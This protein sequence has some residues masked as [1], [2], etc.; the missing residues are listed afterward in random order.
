[1]TATAD[2]QTSV[3]AWKSPVTSY[4]LLLTATSILVLMGL[5][6]VLSS[7]SISSIAS[8][9]GS[10]YSGF[11]TQAIALVVGATAL[12]VGSRLSPA[13]WKI[14][15]PIVLY[16]SMALLVAVP[17]IGT[18]VGGNKAWIRLGSFSFQPSE[19]AKVGLALYLGVV[20]ARFRHGLTTIKA[21][22]VPGGLMA[23]AV[24]ALVLWG[25]DMG[26]ALVLMALILVAF[27]VAGV[28]KRFFGMAGVA[29]VIGL[30]A[31]VNV[32][33]TRLARIEQWFTG[34]C[35][36]DSC[37]QQQHGTWA[38]ASGG[39]GGLGPGMSR[40][41][42]GY[43]PASDNDFIFAIIGEE[44]GLIG[45][46]LVLIAFAL[47]VLAVNRIIQR[48]DDRFVQIAAAGIGAAVCIQACI[49][50]AV[51]LE[52]LPV[53]GV[54]L[55]LVSAGGSSL[56]VSLLAMGVLM[57]FAR[58]EPGAQ[59]VL[60]ARPSLVRRSLSVLSKGRRRG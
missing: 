30:V 33:E 56:I 22:L 11:V 12:L 58:H 38:L 37:W 52:F 35:E 4:Y 49:N 53:T 16:V 28:P 6:V 59:E 23:G 13:T 46:V 2:S 48:S 5:A 51:V 15:G 1:M 36:N 10:A 18:A 40:E 14:L 9:S 17:F 32:G 45:T 41:K 39:I 43:L 50:M 55:P 42:W 20:L 34:S 26:T 27:W 57:S 29:L 8:G 44:F 25:H 3:T 31:L 19:L 21:L 47:I 7:S 54:P 60:T 24:L